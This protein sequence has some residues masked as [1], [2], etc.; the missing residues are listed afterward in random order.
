MVIGLCA[1]WGVPIAGF[2][3]TSF[4]TSSVASTTGWWADWG[5]SSWT[6][7][8]Y[9]Y[10]FH[11]GLG[12]AFLNSLTVTIPA[13]IALVSGAA[14]IAYV[15]TQ[16]LFV[17]RAVTFVTIL[18]FLV[19]PPQV[20]LEPAFKLFAFLHLVGQIPSVWLFQAGFTMP[21]GIFILVAFFQGIPGEII[22]AARIDGASDLQVFLRLVLPLGAPGIVSVLI[23]HFIFSWNDLLTPLLFLNSS[24]APLTVQVAGL[25][26]Q[27]TADTQAAVAAASLLSVLPPVVLFYSLQRY[28]VRGL[29]GGAVKA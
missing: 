25:A 28:F 7:E 20:T 5:G 19:L 6:L 26:Q 27:T 2:V 24:A 12:H 23:L 16:M 1:I 15:L 3:V 14:V 18:A 11:S 4:R 9:R 8:Q 13:N 17:G 22:E 29:T 10:A 21:L